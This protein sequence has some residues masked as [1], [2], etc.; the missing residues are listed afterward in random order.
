[1]YCWGVDYDYN[2]DF[3][4]IFYYCYEFLLY[5]LNKQN[6]SSS[7]C[8]T[9]KELVIQLRDILTRIYYQGYSNND[10]KVPE[11]LE[12][13]FDEARSFLKPSSRQTDIKF[14]IKILILNVFISILDF[15]DASKIY[16]QT[17]DFLIED[18]RLKYLYITTFYLPF[19]ILLASG[20]LS[21][22]NKCI[23]YKNRKNNQT[24][25]LLVF[26]YII[27]F[28]YL[29]INMILVLCYNII[30]MIDEK[31]EYCEYLESI[32]SLIA[33]IIAH[34]KII[35]DYVENYESQ[36]TKLINNSYISKIG[37]TQTK[38][39]IKYPCGFNKGQIFHNIYE[40]NKN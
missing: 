2:S 6:N 24:K 33:I 19:I 32:A 10:L 21:L 37:Y 26:N 14:I 25:R 4:I 23:K 11:E 28:V 34:W 22:I 16:D 17:N 8:L 31:P 20:I 1:M 27:L 3:S 38:K 30:V 35:F 39:K 7:T 13:S 40:W 18:D 29:F 15:N 36:M 5:N 9:Q 12:K